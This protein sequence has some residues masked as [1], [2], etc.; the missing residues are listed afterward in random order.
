MLSV[1]NHSRDIAGFTYVYP[2]ISRR[3]NGLS[4]GINLN[5][6]NACNWRCI[7]CQVPELKRGSAPTIDLQL[8]SNEL[9]RLLDDVQQ[10][11]FYDRFEVPE[12]QRQ[13]RDIAISGNGEPTSA[14]EFSDVVVLLGEAAKQTSLLGKINIVLITNGSL[15][16]QVPVQDGLNAL[17]Q[18]DGE[19]WFKL[20]SATDS[21]LREINNASSSLERARLNL[22]I[23]V[24]HCPLWVQTCLFA[25]D[26]KPP[27]VVDWQAY[28][29]LLSEFKN[30]EHQ[31]LGVLL[32]GLARQSLQP[33]VLRLERLSEMQMEDYAETIRTLG[34]EVKVSY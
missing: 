25:L 23:A 9:H 2:V 7:Y 5:P 27:S 24:K 3:A 1:N 18:L 13:I 26:G 30:K 17:A 12:H 22:S 8:L 21:G 33:E 15:I 16:H 11:D 14:R 19:V 6:N 29:N 32:Y 10:G 31:P 34:Y 20:D 28:L 4:I